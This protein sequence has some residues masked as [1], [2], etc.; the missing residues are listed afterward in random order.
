MNEKRVII[1]GVAVLVAG[2]LAAETW[3]DD[4]RWQATEGSSAPT[5]HVP[6]E[7]SE[8]SV[9]RVSSAPAPNVVAHSVSSSANLS[10][11]SNRRVETRF[12]LA[13][14]FD[15]GILGGKLGK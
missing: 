12:M 2:S 6:H 7:R 1:A 11:E 4:H 13:G 10:F 5:D 8:E 9:V 15:Y 14:D 3:R